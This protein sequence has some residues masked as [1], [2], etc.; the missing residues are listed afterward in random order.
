MNYNSRLDLL[1]KSMNALDEF[2]IYNF[3]REETQ[4]KELEFYS[5]YTEYD[6]QLKLFMKENK[7]NLFTTKEL[8][9][10]SQLKKLTSEHISF[11]LKMLEKNSERIT[12]LKQGDN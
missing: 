4:I 6:T 8:L 3:K 10:E 9:K 1:L 11:F 7:L 5:L 12:S 2:I